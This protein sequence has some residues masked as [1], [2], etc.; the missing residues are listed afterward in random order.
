MSLFTFIIVEYDRIVRVTTAE[1]MISRWSALLLF[2][3]TCRSMHK[4]TAHKSMRNLPDNYQSID[5]ITQVRMSSQDTGGSGLEGGEGPARG[6][7][8]STRAGRFRTGGQF[9]TVPLGIS[10]TKLADSRP[11]S[12]ELNTNIATTD[13]QINLFLLPSANNNNRFILPHQPHYLIINL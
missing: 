5:V 12:P 4:Y 2:V 6:G 9:G 10:Y 1:D 7:R 8:E 11:N 3:N 13:C